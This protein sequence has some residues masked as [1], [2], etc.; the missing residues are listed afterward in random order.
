MDDKQLSSMDTETNQGPSQPGLNQ[1]PT[2]TQTAAP[3]TSSSVA[4]F[5]YVLIGKI[6]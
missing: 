6:G 3:D 1:V 2:T 4:E 5:Q